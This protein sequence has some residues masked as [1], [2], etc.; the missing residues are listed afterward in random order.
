V[1]TGLAWRRAAPADRPLALVLLLGA[2]GAAALLPWVPLFARFAPACPFHAW[3]GLPCPGCGTT[4]AVTALAGGDLAGA[5]AWNPLATLGLAAGFLVAALALPWVEARAPV[6][7]LRPGGLPA[8]SRA[9][10]AAA[11]AAQWAWLVAARV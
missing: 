8:W 10:A 1:T 9:L 5:F 2:A 11:L 6:P 7:V 4:R 3:T